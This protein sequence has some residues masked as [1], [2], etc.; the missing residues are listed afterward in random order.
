MGLKKCVFDCFILI[1][2]EHRAQHNEDS[3]FL[4]TSIPTVNN[5]IFQ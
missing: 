5:F 4:N 3:L 1:D 2:E